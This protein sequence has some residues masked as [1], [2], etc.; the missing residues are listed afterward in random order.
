MWLE[1][2][3]ITIGNNYNTA[4]KIVLA[5]YIKLCYDLCNFWSLGITIGSLS[6]YSTYFTSSQDILTNHI[7]T[8]TVD[9]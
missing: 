1:Y 8:N 6:T 7:S 9:V 5:A 4:T 2:F 3:H